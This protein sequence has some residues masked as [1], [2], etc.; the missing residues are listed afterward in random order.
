MAACYTNGLANCTP[1]HSKTKNIDIL[2]CLAVGGCRIR[3]ATRWPWSSPQRT[4]FVKGYLC[5]TVNLRASHLWYSHYSD[6]QE[7]PYRLIT[8][9]HDSGMGYRKIACW[10]NEHGYTTP[11]G[12]EFK[13]THVFSI[14]K[15]KKVRDERLNKCYKFEVKNLRICRVNVTN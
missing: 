7:S 4:H 1:D 14:L 3:L 12:H 5:F 8:T 15:K 10:L 13:N 2:W 9:M 6:Y 11:R